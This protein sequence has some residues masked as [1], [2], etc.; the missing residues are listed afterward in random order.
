MTVVIMDMEFERV[1]DKNGNTEVNTT[2][3]R[4]NLVNIERVKHVVKE[5]V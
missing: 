1:N 4:E 5:R 3:A 2:A